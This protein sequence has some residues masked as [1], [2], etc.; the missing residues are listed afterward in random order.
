MFLIGFNIW[1][2]PFASY[3]NDKK[4]TILLP[5]EFPTC[6]SYCSTTP[7]PLSNW[8]ISLHDTP[9]STRE[10]SGFIVA[11]AGGGGLFKT[12][13]FLAYFSRRK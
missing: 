3:S 6:P 11:G 13:Y 5:L 10:C 8:Q 2:V 4:G 1:R 7:T 12:F 9:V